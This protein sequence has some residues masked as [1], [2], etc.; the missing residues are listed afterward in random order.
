MFTGRQSK[1]NWPILKEDVHRAAARAELVQM[2]RKQVPM[3]W[4]M[5]ILDKCMIWLNMSSVKF[6]SCLNTFYVQ[7]VGLPF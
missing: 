6:I 2:Q 4:W 3:D 7:M 5:D 1:L